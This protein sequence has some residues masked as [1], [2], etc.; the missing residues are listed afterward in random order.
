MKAFLTDP[1]TW[2]ALAFVIF[3]ALIAWKAWPGMMKGL[4]ARAAKIKAE[5]DEAERLR[6]EAQKLLAD[7]QRKQKEAL[8]EAEAMIRQAEEEAK[9]MRAKAEAE[10]DASIKRREKQALD[11]IAQAEAAAAAEV[12][13]LAVDV[14]VAAA[15]KVLAQ[16]Q[17]PARAAQR[18]DAAI[19]DLPRRLQ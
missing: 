7:Y 3:V 19:A 6:D 17:D 12:R 2:V 16:G 10:L 18:I 1:T 4:D 11:R 5:L 14:A 9:R 8:A 13:N 15:A